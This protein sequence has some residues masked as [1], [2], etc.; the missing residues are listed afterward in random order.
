MLLAVPATMRT[1]WASSNEFRSFA[2]SLA[3]SAN[4]CFV[5]FPTLS[6]FGTPEPLA[7]PAAFFSSAAAGGV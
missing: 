5:T 3:I 7:I 4:C 2:F 1:A 6:R